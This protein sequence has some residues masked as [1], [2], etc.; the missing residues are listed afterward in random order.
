MNQSHPMP[1]QRANNVSSSPVQDI[2]YIEASNIASGDLAAERERR[3]A[4]YA[5]QLE[6][7]GVVSAK[8]E[9]GNLCK[10]VLLT[11]VGGGNGM[12]F[13]SL[14]AAARHLKEDPGN[15]RQAARLG[16]ECRGFRVKVL[17]GAARKPSSN[18]CAAGVRCVESG[19][20]FDSM[21]QAADETGVPISA[22]HRS[23]HTGKSARGLTFEF[24]SPFRTITLTPFTWRP[25]TEPQLLLP[26]V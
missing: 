9:G 19:Q 6:A 10:Q 14:R 3:V 12:T 25:R 1:F 22:V 2:H 20:M 21:T 11:P 24:T 7:A 13:E 16:W 17:K 26:F 15:V 4:E 18:G 8:R 5:R 23:V